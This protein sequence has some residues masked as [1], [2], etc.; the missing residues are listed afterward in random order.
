MFD[1]V[2]ELQEIS[3]KHEILM[4]YIDYICAIID[5]Y[6]N[7]CLSRNIEGIKKVKDIGLNFDLIVNCIGNSNVHEK[8]KA[9]FIYAAKVLYIDNDPFPSLVNYKNRC[10]L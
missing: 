8:F 4:P 7:I 10:Y 5:L 2:F 9:S 1:I 3:A 6:S